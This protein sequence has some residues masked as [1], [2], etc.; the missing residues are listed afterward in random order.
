V[1]YD[2]LV[3]DGQSQKSA[4]ASSEPVQ[5]TA[6]ILQTRK[7]RIAESDEEEEKDDD[8]SFSS[9]IKR[10][11]VQQ[12]ESFNSAS[13]ASL[14]PTYASSVTVMPHLLSTP[15]AAPS[16]SMCAS[17]Y[18]SGRYLIAVMEEPTALLSPDSPPAFMYEPSEVSSD[19]ASSLLD[20]SSTSLLPVTM[21]ESVRQA[22]DPD[23]TGLTSMELEKSVSVSPEA[24][25][26]TGKGMEAA[27]GASATTTP[28]EHGASAIARPAILA[29]PAISVASVLSNSP[30]NTPVPVSAGAATTVPPQ[31]LTAMLASTNQA[32]EP[33][34]IPPALAQEITATDDLPAEVHEWRDFLLA[35]GIETIADLRSTFYGDGTFDTSEVKEWLVWVAEDPKTSLPSRSHG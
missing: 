29:S 31:L 5:V 22:G 33:A 27:P 9:S 2:V 35:N 21:L 17:V 3:T 28:S 32:T 14:N 8:L 11:K 10:Q 16:S 1:T 7:K 12:G 18:P 24:L 4:T 19:S 13:E 26:A 25:A 6:A 20:T 15:I 34:V 30:R 23:M